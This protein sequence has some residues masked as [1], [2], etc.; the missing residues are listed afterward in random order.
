M[1]RPLG[2]VVPMSHVEER[3]SFSVFFFFC[4]VA[5]AA[6]VVLHMNAEVCPSAVPAHGCCAA[7]AHHSPPPTSNTAPG[8]AASAREIVLPRVALRRR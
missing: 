2:P 5:G 4:M 6:A 8:P 7:S 3:R 1:V